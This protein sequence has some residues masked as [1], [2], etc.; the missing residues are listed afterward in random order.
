MFFNSKKISFVFVVVLIILFLIFPEVSKKVVTLGLMTVSNIIIPSLFPFLVCILMIMK[1]NVS[2]KNNVINGILYELFGQNFDMFFA[3]VLSLVGGYPVGSKLVNELYNKKTI[4]SKSANIMLMYCVNAGPAF[5]L[6]TVTNKFNKSIAIVLLASHIS[7]TVIMALFLSKNL[8]KNKCKLNVIK[9]TTKSFSEIFVESVADACSS[10]LN[11]SAFIIFFSSVNAY[12]DC[13]AE[14]MPIIKYISFFTEVTSGVLKC[15][16]VFLVSFLLGFSGFSIWCQSF[17]LSRS[18][19]INYLKFILGRLLHGGIS[20]MIT[21]IL[22]E[23]LN[24]KISV[25][26]NN[27]NFQKQLYYSDSVLFISMIVMLII[28]MTYIYSKNNSGKLLRDVI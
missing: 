10:I 1:S 24:I 3:F 17:S 11:I 14:K 6:S 27:Q 9:K 19:N 7:A 15:N 2:I 16:N 4:D 5:I 20:V 22:I 26:N 18:I 21:K 12:A 13:F 25:F 28:L 8:K 23:I